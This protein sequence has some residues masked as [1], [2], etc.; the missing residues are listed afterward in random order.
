MPLTLLKGL[1]CTSFGNTYF[2]IRMLTDP[3]SRR[4]LRN[5]LLLT[6]PIVLV[7]AIVARVRFCNLTLSRV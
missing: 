1:P 7:T 5:L 3:E 4:T 2:L 6:A